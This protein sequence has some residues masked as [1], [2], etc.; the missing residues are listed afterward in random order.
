MTGFFIPR[1][2]CGV[3]MKYWEKYCAKTVTSPILWAQPIT[4]Q[5]RFDPKNSGTPIELF[6]PEMILKVKMVIYEKD[7]NNNCRNQCHIC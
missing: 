2:G 5:C 7:T 3:F 6:I 4:R 1:S